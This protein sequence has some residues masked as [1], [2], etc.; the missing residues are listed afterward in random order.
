MDPKTI[1]HTNNPCNG[2]YGKCLDVKIV[3]ACNGKCR[4]CIEAGGYQ[5]RVAPVKRLINATNALTDYQKVLILGG[6]PFLYHALLEYL[7]GIRDK[8]EI[9]ITTNGTLF[10]LW[11]SERIAEYLTAINISIHHYSQP[12]NAA[13]VG[14]TADF[15]DIYEAIKVFK[16][17]GVRIRINTNLI[18]GVLRDKSDIQMMISAAQNLGADEIRFAE[19]QY[20]PELFVSAESL[21]GDLTE[22]SDDPFTLGCEHLAF[23]D[24]GFKVWVRQACGLVNPHRAEPLCPTRAGSQTKVLYPDGMVSDG[25]LQGGITSSP[26]GQSTK[27][28]VYYCHKGCHG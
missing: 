2:F 23:A 7:E 15:I 22:L 11:P 14:T 24:G 17:N 10:H 4:F 25:W 13:V 6:E 12:I 3:N 28:R 26:G 19:L 5:P 21:F 16:A 9:Y 20:C 8:Q 1:C 27:K 18:K